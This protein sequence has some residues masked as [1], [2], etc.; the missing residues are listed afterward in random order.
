[1]LSQ[2]DLMWL[3]VPPYFYPQHTRIHILSHLLLFPELS[4]YSCSLSAFGNTNHAD[5]KKS[6]YAARLLTCFSPR[7]LH[8]C[9][10]KHNL[11]R[12][13]ETFAFFML[14]LHFLSKSK[15]SSLF[16]AVPWNLS[17]L[18][19]YLWLRKPELARAGSYEL[20]STFLLSRW[21]DEV[22]AHGL[23]T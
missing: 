20:V 9:Y 23:V 10:S 17:L 1:M 18:T 12:T 22:I 19:R 21:K 11:V 13:W 5:R 6:F 4:E 2:Q 14:T 16:G 15:W 8:Y 3:S 7:L